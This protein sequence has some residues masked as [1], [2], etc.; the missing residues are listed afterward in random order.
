MGQNPNCAP[1]AEP[2]AR[3]IVTDIP[4]ESIKL[5]MFA[6]DGRAVAVPLSPDR[7]LRIAVELIEAATR[8][9]G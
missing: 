2:M 8:R 7:A 5:A 6:E 3:A 9:L 1:A 4:T